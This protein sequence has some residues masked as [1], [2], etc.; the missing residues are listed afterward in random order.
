MNYKKYYEKCIGRAVLAEHEIHHL[1]SDRGNNHISNL[2]EIPKVLHKQIHNAELR[3][4]NL[5]I[6]LN[7]MRAFS[8]FD[9]RMVDCIVKDYM[10]ARNSVFDYEMVRDEL[11][12][13]NNF[14]EEIYCKNQKGVIT[15]ILEK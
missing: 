15:K 6:N 10:P 1:D 3:L 7:N 8:K 11:L 4:S 5:I 9:E 2:V 12:R 14:S 13:E